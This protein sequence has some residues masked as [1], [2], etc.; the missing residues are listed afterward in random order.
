[1]EYGLKDGNRKIE[2]RKYYKERIIAFVDILG[3]KTLVEESVTNKYEF[4]KILDSLNIF[5]ELKK[6]KENQYY[7]EDAKVTTFSDS[8]VISYPMEDGNVEALYSILL[9]LIGLQLDLL[10][11]N[12]IIRG[13]IAIGNLRHTQSEIFGPAM[14]EA[15]RLES[16]IAKYPRIVICKETVEN[17]LKKTTSEEQNKDKLDKLLKW[18]NSDGIYYLD[19][20]GNSE[21]FCAFGDYNLMLDK[22][23]SIIRHGKQ[24]GDEKTRGKYLWLE[25]YFREVL[26]EMNRGKEN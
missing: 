22:I 23:A 20:L 12:V 3:F 14:N 26:D 19:Y 7:I 13:G 1:M 18:D 16:K 6:E 11:D 8:L 17:Y 10:D 15:Y 25:R 21:L 9:D 24:T 4:Q 5:R 2:Y